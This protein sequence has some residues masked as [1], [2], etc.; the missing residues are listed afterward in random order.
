ML[1]RLTAF[2]LTGLEVSIKYSVKLSGNV[3]QVYKPA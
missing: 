2:M 1:L 3:V